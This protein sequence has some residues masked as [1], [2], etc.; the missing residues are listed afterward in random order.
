[1]QLAFITKIDEPIVSKTF[2]IGADNP[3]NVDLTT[4]VGKTMTS[5]GVYEFRL[6]DDLTTAKISDPTKVSEVGTYYVVERSS[7]G[8]CVSN[9]VKITVNITTANSQGT[10][11]EIIETVAVPASDPDVA[12]PEVISNQTVQSTDTGA[13]IA[14]IE[15]NDTLDALGIPGGFSPNGDKVN[16]VFQIKNLGETEASLRVYNRYG[17]LV[18]DAEKYQ[19]N[20]DG[21]PNNSL[22]TNSTMGLPDGTYYYSLKLKDG[23]QKISFLTIAR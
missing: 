22:L 23:R 6:T 15:P 19:N 7:G 3:Q 13:A 11:P 10:T 16:D 8:D 4:A 12:Q 21:K 1:L 18:Y 9:S 2:T 20:W 5:G 14:S 17:H